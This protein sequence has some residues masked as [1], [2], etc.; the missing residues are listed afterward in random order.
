VLKKICDHPCLLTQRAA[1]DIADGIETMLSAQDSAA[2]E[3]MSASVAKL[4]DNSEDIGSHAILS[5]KIA[6]MM[7]LLVRYMNIVRKHN[8]SHR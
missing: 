3:A 5:C 7:T 2:A 6:F 8:N 1:D 4:L